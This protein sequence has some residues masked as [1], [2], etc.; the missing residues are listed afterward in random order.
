ML[1]FLKKLS[2]KRL[3]VGFADALIDRINEKYEVEVDVRVRLVDAKPE[4]PKVC[5]ED[6]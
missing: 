3:A 5:L 1:G 6:E 4:V 2:P